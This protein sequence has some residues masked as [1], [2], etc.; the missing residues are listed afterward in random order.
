MKLETRK[1]YEE[2]AITAYKRANACTVEA[3]NAKA[4]GDTDSWAYYT[5]EAKYFAEDA[6]ED[7][8]IALCDEEWAA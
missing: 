7:A 5:R 3:L 1:D 4:A 6:S 8:A 2:A